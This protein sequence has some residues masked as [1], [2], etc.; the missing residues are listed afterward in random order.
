MGLTHSSREV[1]AELQLGHQKRQEFEAELEIFRKGF[2]KK[3]ETAS[4]T[5]TAIFQHLRNNF[6]ASAQEGINA[7]SRTSRAAQD[8]IAKLNQVSP[9]P[10]LMRSNIF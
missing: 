10:F 1:V 9:F 3:L 8:I 6:E 4:G 7:V 2:M 5:L